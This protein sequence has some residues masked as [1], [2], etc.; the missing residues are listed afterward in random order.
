MSER[1]ITEGHDGRGGPSEVGQA[2]ADVM[3][4]T[5]DLFDGSPGVAQALG[6][7]IDRALLTIRA[8]PTPVSHQLAAAILRE[9]MNEALLAIM[10]GDVAEG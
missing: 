8:T 2:K 4:L 10:V 9:K 6:V 3:L 5:A 1:R 7:A